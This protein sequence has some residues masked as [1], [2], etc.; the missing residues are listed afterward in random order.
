MKIETDEYMSIER[1]EEV[2][3]EARKI[4]KQYLQARKILINFN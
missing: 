4:R 3:S 1:R 2:R